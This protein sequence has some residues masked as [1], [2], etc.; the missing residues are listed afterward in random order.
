MNYKR[1]GIKR[2][3]DEQFNKSGHHPESTPKILNLPPRPLGKK[4]LKTKITISILS[5]H[6]SLGVLVV[7]KLI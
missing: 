3:N 5:D 4:E 2:K 7:K 1:L 6:S